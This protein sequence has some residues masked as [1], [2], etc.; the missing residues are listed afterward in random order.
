M[1]ISLKAARVNA[2]YTQ[3]EVGDYVGKSKNTIA[4]YESYETQPDVLTAQKM[5]ELYGVSVDNI[6]WA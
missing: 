6:K 5:A 3:K 1:E 4:S 2:G